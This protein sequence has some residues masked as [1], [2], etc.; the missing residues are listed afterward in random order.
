M[1]RSK[2][3]R[4]P[5]TRPLGESLPALKASVS[6]FKLSLEGVRFECC[7]RK[8]KSQK[9]EITCSKCGSPLTKIVTPTRKAHLICSTAGCCVAPVKSFLTE[10]EMW[11]W[12]E[13]GWILTSEKCQDGTS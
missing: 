11:E 10:R 12:L 4:P 8:G 5:S 7:C 3:P 13:R 6:Q 1:R 2:P 9:R